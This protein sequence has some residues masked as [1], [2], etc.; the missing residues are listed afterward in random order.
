MS[1]KSVGLA[2]VLAGGL[3]A[4]TA[5]A[6]YAQIV[7]FGVEAAQSSSAEPGGGS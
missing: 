3:S 7:P 5:S 6:N 4:W 1:R 2:L